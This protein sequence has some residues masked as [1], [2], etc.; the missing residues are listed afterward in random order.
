[1]AERLKLH[2]ELCELIGSKNVYFDP[3]ESIK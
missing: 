2:Q 3:P 1:M